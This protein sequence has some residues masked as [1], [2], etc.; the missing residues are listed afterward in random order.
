MESYQKKSILHNSDQRLGTYPSGIRESSEPVKTQSSLRSMTMLSLAIYASSQQPSC[1]RSSPRSLLELPS[2]SL[3]AK[4]GGWRR[5]DNGLGGGGPSS[6]AWSWTVTMYKK[7]GE[8]CGLLVR[9]G[10]TCKGSAIPLSAIRYYTHVRLLVP[11]VRAL[12]S[13]CR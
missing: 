9:P 11:H 4:K 1:R 2:S 5:R 10:P 3:K 7:I 6:G 13:H 8:F 12:W